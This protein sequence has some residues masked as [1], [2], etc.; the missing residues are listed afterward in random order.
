MFGSSLS[1]IIKFGA[2][3]AEIDCRR[4][5]INHAHSLLRLAV[6]LFFKVFH[7]HSFVAIFP[8]LTLRARCVV[9]RCTPMTTE[10][11]ENNGSHKGRLT[12]RESPGF[13]HAVLTHL[14]VYV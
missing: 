6:T 4:H 10:L 1:W 9:P 12:R 14:R 5:V 13:R 7:V 2:P 8:I 11:R 3:F